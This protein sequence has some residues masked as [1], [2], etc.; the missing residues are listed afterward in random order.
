MLP[1]FIS[2]DFDISTCCVPWNISSRATKKEVKGDDDF[3]LLTVFF[4]YISETKDD[5]VA[6]GVWTCDKAMMW[7]TKC[8]YEPQLMGTYNLLLYFDYYPENTLKTSQKFMTQTQMQST[9]PGS[10]TIHIWHPPT[11]WT[12]IRTTPNAYT[13][14]HAHIPTPKSRGH[15]IFADM[16]QTRSHVL[17]IVSD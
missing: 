1:D 15:L 11:S 17:P 14:S 16:P 12:T 2:S 13:Q 5:G 6:L 3:S 4:I 7:T 10:I 9:Q 8:R